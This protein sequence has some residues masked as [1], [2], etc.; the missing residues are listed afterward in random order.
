MML[1][2]YHNLLRCDDFNGITAW[3]RVADESKNNKVIF[4]QSIDFNYFYFFVGKLR[5]WHLSLSQKGDVYHF[6]L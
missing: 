1:M 6:D 3:R 5:Q 2:K 4:S